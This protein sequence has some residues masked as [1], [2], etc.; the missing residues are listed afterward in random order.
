MKTQALKLIGS[1]VFCLMI[2]PQIVISSRYQL[3]SVIDDK[4]YINVCQKEVLRTVIPNYKVTSDVQTG[5]ESSFKVRNICPE[6]LYTCC[7]ADGL[8]HLF[9]FYNRTLQYARY[10]ENEFKTLFDTILNITD[11][12]F[13]EFLEKLSPP[14][15]K[16]YMNQKKEGEKNRDPSLIMNEFVYLK[17][18]APSLM[19]VIKDDTRE[20]ETFFSGFLC[21]MCSP[22]FYKVF[23]TNDKGKNFLQVNEN[24]CNDSLNRKIK[25]IDTILIFKNV[26]KIIDI[27]ICAKNNSM[28]DFTGASGKINWSRYTYVTTENKNLLKHRK[29]LVQ[30]TTNADSYYAKNKERNDCVDI[31]RENMNFG[32]T[33]YEDM[34]PLIVIENEIHN[35]FFENADSEKL[36]N[37]LETKKRRYFQM[38][39]GLNFSGNISDLTDHGTYNLVNVKVVKKTTL[40]LNHLELIVEK[41]NGLNF[42][43]YKSNQEII[44]FE[45]NLMFG[46]VLILNALLWRVA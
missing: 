40:D 34:M 7:D 39:D 21:S 24:M 20:R 44:A 35:F 3:S 30:C 37:R 26:Q 10:R 14:D 2:L 9:K 46:F 17:S 36:R 25:I 16:C 15:V 6:L 13:S 33:L 28:K 22:Y 27:T 12:M 1:L 11:E 45:A 4:K 41:L 18:V 32:G 29:D 31:C 23:S 8:E 43:D 5:W 42:E 19:K 38:K